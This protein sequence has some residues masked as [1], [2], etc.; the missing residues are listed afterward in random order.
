MCHSPCKLTEYFACHKKWPSKISEK[1]AENGWNVICNA[2]PI[3]EWSDHD[4]SMKPSVRNPPRNRGYILAR[5]E[6]FLLTNTTF[7][8]RTIILNFT[9]YTVPATKSDADSATSPNTAPATK[10]DSHDQSSSH[11]K[12]YLQ[13]A[14]TWLSYDLTE[15]WL[16]WAVTWLNYWLDWATDLTELL[17]DWAMTWLSYDLTELLLDWAMTWLNMTW[18][19]YDLLSYDLTELW[20]N[21]AMTWLSFD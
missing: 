15:L 7:R 2:R 20:L 10:Y 21:W 13:W 3:R 6:H 19:S 17:L 1:F 12:H 14:M 4:P 11:I 16:D 5:H 8:A 9:E 18:L